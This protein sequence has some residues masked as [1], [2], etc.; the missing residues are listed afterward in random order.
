MAVALVELRV[1]PGQCVQKASHAGQLLSYS[2]LTGIVSLPCLH[3]HAH[4]HNNQIKCDRAL[5][6]SS[7]S[8][9]SNI[10]VC[11]ITHLCTFGFIMEINWQH[12]LFSLKHVSG[13]GADCIGTNGA[14]GCYHRL[15]SCNPFAGQRRS[16]LLPELFE[17]QLLTLVSSFDQD[18]SEVGMLNC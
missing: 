11:N 10:S 2:D 1:G 18:L 13:A 15:I 5:N 3:K 16:C 7:I 9:T 14:K 12:T 4:V 8:P 17:S 6:C